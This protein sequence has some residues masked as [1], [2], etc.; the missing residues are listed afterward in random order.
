MAVV[1]AFAGLIEQRQRGEPLHP[2]VGRH[3]AVEHVAQDALILVRDR[4][5]RAEAIGEPR[6]VGEEIVEGDLARR[7]HGLIERTLGILQHTG[8]LELRRP[9]R[10]G[11]VELE[12]ALL[13]QHQGGER[14]HWLGH[15]G[16]AE[17]RVAL[18][19]QLLLDVALAERVDLRDF[20][21]AVEK[22]D[23]AGKIARI[24]DRLQRRHD[25]GQAVCRETLG[26]GDDF[27]HG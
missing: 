21:M 20:A 23:E 1:E 5:H 11:I 13:H 17:E 2:I 22:R 25:L 8:I 3:L 24:H 12:L 6:T 15:R 7:R 27:I 9:F 14:R 19:G 10:D 26:V 16:D 4:T 18:H